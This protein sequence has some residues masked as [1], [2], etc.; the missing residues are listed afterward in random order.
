VSSFA[1]VCVNI[2][3]TPSEDIGSIPSV[4]LGSSALDEFRSTLECVRNGFVR[5]QP[6]AKPRREIDILYGIWIVCE[7]WAGNGPRILGRCRQ[8][9]TKPPGSAAVDPLQCAGYVICDRLERLVVG[10]VAMNPRSLWPP[11]L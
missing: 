8:T 11:Q 1:G 7:K 4:E 3:S 10:I 2:V 6:V 9:H 5:G